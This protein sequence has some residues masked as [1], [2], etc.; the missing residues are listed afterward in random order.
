MRGYGRVISTEE[1][2]RYRGVWCGKG[3]HWNLSS[4]LNHCCLD[5][6]LGW[7]VLQ[8]FHSQVGSSANPDHSFIWG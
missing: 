6:A 1:I 5:F 3:I 2:K 7:R 8:G 4:M